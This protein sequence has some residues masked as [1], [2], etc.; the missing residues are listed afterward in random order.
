MVQIDSVNGADPE[1]SSD[2]V[3]FD[4][5][6]PIN[7]TERLRLETNSTNLIGRVI[8][9]VAPIGKGQRGLILSPAKAGKTT[10]LQSV[11]ASI[12]ANNPECHLMVVLVEERPERSEARRGGKLWVSTCRSRWSQEH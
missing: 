8:D 12:T 4:K 5:L 3:D 2:R 7:P 6:T 11:A 10:L 9:V 1:S